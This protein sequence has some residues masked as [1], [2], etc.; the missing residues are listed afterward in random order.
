[1]EHHLKIVAKNFQVDEKELTEFAL[2]N[3]RRYGIRQEG[4]YVTTTTLFSQDLLRDFD[5][6]KNGTVLIKGSELTDEQKAMLK[7]NGMKNPEF[8]ANH[9]FWFKDGKPATEDRFLYP[10]CH[11]LSHLPH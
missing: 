4:S 8:V 3:P 7:F 1:M 6:Y 2:K 9:S 11:S 5:L 10:V